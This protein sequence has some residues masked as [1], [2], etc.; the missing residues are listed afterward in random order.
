MIMSKETKI[1]VLVAEP[2]KKPYVKEIENT[3]ESLQREVGGCIQAIYPF[4]K[5]AAI[6][7][8]E[9]AKPEGLP[10]NRALRDE[11]GNIYDIIVGTFLVVGLTED[12]FGSLN[13]E[14][15]KNMLEYFK[16]PEM[17]IYIN[18]KLAVIPSTDLDI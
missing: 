6:V 1:A 10:L 4:E 12:D 7:C 2:Q 9:C 8:A 3:L 17:L 18:G 14:L 11:N 16:T 15:M 13:D 5:P